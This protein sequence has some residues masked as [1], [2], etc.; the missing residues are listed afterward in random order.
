MYDTVRRSFAPVAALFQYDRD[1]WKLGEEFL[2]GLWAVNDE[3]DAVPDARLEWSIHAS[4]GAVVQRGM[5]PVS[6]AADSSHLV[7]KVKWM[8]H[9]PGAYELR[10][11]IVGKGSKTISENVFEFQVSADGLK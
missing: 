8:A 4:G 7:G 2:C 9:A 3:W 6:M 1:T 11:A 5:F 10:A